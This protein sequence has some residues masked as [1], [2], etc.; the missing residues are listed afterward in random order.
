MTPLERAR[1]AWGDAMPD[2]VEQLAIR[3]GQTSQ[4][5]VAVRLS[6]SSAVVSLVL[7]NNYPA[8]LRLIEERVRGVLM[9]TT[10]QCP[11]L[12]DVP[13]HECQDWREKGRVFA[14]GNPLRRQMYRACAACPRNRKAEE[15]PDIPPSPASA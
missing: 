7:S 11:A 8:D 12:G 1:A 3:C 9:S 13:L 10:V 5:K 15:I 6:R 4:A 14:P 2:W